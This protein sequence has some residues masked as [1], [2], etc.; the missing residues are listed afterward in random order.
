MIQNKKA[1]VFTHFDVPNFGANLQAHA[2]SKFLKSYSIDAYFTKIHSPALESK[3]KK[4]VSSAQLK[5]HKRFAETNLEISDIGKLDTN[6]LQA[7]INSDFDFVVTG[8]DAVFKL[9]SNA[10]DRAELVYPNHYWLPFETSAKKFSFSAS[11]MGTIFSQNIPRSKT[12]HFRGVVESFDLI[13]VRDRWTKSQLKKYVSKEV[14]ITPDPVF[15]LGNAGSRTY[16][17]YI[18]ICLPKR[19][20]GDWEKSLITEIHR[21]G[22]DVK[23]VQTPEEI[24]DN[25]VDPLEWYNLIANSKGYV[26]VRFHPIVIAISNGLPV[27]ALDQY[28]KYPWNKQQSKTNDLVE[29]YAPNGYVASKFEQF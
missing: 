20:R 5:M 9:D 4:C 25:V 24:T 2:V 16:G 1:L 13:T 8:S 18:A 17:D 21:I 11:S 3:Y 14:H 10:Q 29:R 6:D 7:E 12:A 15:T 22:L 23:Y 26:G 28:S 27:V 19:L